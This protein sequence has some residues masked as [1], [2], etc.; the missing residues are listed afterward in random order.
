LLKNQACAKWI[1][2]PAQDARFTRKAQWLP[3]S[4]TLSDRGSGSRQPSAAAIRKLA[5]FRPSFFA[6]IPP[7]VTCFMPAEAGPRCR[8]SQLLAGLVAGRGGFYGIRSRAAAFGSRLHLQTCLFRYFAGFVGRSPMIDLGH[9]PRFTKNASG[10]FNDDVIWALP[11]EAIGR[12]QRYQ[13]AASATSTYSVGW[14]P[15]CRP[16]HPMPRWS[17]SDG[18]EDHRTAHQVLARALGTPKP[19]RSGPRGFSAASSS[20]TRTIAPASSDALLARKSNGPP[21]PNRATGGTCS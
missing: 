5:A 11:G 21:R 13:A 16:V 10:C 7:S 18:Q 6:S 1:N 20:A 17:G 15:C 4:P 3:V 2:C 14:P 12:S 19:G 8:P 9:P